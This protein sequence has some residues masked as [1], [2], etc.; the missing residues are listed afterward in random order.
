METRT[1][2]KS[3]IFTTDI[4]AVHI[5]ATKL[6]ENTGNCSKKYF[7]INA[8]KLRQNSLYVPRRALK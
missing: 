4:F 7:L 6:Q 2:L 8:V 5:T 1:Q 3:V